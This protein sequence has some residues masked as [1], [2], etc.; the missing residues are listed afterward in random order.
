[1]KIDKLY[2]TYTPEWFKENA[3]SFS[4]WFNAKTFNWSRGSS[5]L[6]IYCSKDCKEWF[7]TLKTTKFDWRYSSLLALHCGKD[8]KRWFDPEKYDFDYGSHLL[9]RNCIKHIDI[10]YDE[11]KYSLSKE[12]ILENSK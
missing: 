11:T 10:W 2:V 4:E 8:F 3:D 9:V 12:E 7:K 1:M 5:L 6:A